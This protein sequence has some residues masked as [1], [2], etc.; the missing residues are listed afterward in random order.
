MNGLYTSNSIK[1]TLR[2]INP[3]KLIIKPSWDTVL[4]YLV[5]HLLIYILKNL[6]LKLFY[7]LR[8]VVIFK[9]LD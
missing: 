4:E 8:V 3:I 1:F 2:S 7:F 6:K 9:I 5:F